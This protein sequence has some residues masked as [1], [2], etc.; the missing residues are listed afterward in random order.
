[1]YNRFFTFLEKKLI[2]S[3]QFGFRQKQ[4]TIHALIHLTEL[5]RKQLYD[6]SYGCGC[7]VDFQKTFNT[8]EHDIL[9]KKLQYYGVTRISNKCFVSYLININQF[10]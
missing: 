3:F 4:S 2:Y 9:L 6:G 10:V 7:F 5:I 1:M 8:V